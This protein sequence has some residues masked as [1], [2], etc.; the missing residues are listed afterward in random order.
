M[1]VFA[2]FFFEFII[3]FDCLFA[4][5]INWLYWANTRSERGGIRAGKIKKETARKGGTVLKKKERDRKGHAVWE[6][7]RI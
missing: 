5:R 1:V 6:S 4:G 7:H 2:C 3:V